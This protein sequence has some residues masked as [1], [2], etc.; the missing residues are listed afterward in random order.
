MNNWSHKGNVNPYAGKVGLDPQ[1]AK[2]LSEMKKHEA[3]NER[4]LH[5]DDK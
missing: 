3:A 1:T 5:A 2:T 4:A